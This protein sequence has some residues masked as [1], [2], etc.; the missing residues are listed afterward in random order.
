L[1]ATTPDRSHHATQSHDLCPQPRR[2]RECDVDLIYGKLRRRIE[3]RQA[4]E[5][6]RV[7]RLEFP[8]QTEVQR[9]T[10]V[11]LPIVLGEER[12]VFALDRG[13]RRDAQTPR[14]RIAEQQ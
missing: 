3:I 2:I 4:I 11:D 12:I 6:L 9:Q 10:A 13:L 7:R 5:S 8:T 1:H 14:S